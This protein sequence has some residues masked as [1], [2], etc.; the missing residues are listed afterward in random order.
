MTRSERVA[1]ARA[2]ASSQSSGGDLV[3]SPP[4]T[5]IKESH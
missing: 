4:T 1:D 3:D 5:P 2:G